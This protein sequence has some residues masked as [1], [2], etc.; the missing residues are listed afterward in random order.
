[1]RRR[2]V[3]NMLLA[4]G[5]DHHARKRTAKNFKLELT[6]MEDRHLQRGHS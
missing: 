1:M 6:A 4:D 2:I 3:S 5:W